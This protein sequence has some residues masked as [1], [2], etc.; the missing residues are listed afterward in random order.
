MSYF[1][2]LG[3]SSVNPLTMKQF[4]RGYTVR[5]KGLYVEMERHE[6]VE[7]NISREK[8]GIYNYH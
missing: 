5:T 1:A 2:Y 6:Y 3:G 7:K 8:I 4:P